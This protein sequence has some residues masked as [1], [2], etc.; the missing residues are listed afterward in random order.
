MSL[1]CNQQSALHTRTY[2]RCLIHHRIRQVPWNRVGANVNKYRQWYQL[3]YPNIGT[4]EQSIKLK[5]YLE[6]LGPNGKQTAGHDWRF[7]WFRWIGDC[8]GLQWHQF[9]LEKP[10]ESTTSGKTTWMALPPE[11]ICIC[12]NDINRW[13][14]NGAVVID[15]WIL[16]NWW[17]MDFDFLLLHLESRLDFWCSGTK[18]RVQTE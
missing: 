17:K 15:H 11:L 2:R 12:C 16:T 18:I 7:K 5:T 6:I 13:Q 4:Y 14:H 1:I 8:F 3:W 10:I 9:I